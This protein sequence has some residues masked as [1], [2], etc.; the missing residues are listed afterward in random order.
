M[1]SQAKETKA[2]INRTST[3][4]AKTKN[5]CTEKKTINKT[6]RQPTEWETIFVN[7]MSDEGL[8]SKI[9][10]KNSSNSISVYGQSRNRNTEVEHKGMDTKGQG[11]G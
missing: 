8:I 10:I 7:D 6:K 11:V 2:K 9:Y 5:F 1:S 4:S 3:E